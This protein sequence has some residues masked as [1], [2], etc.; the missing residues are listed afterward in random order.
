M[1]VRLIP[2]SHNPARKIIYYGE[3]VDGEVKVSEKL[4]IYEKLGDLCC[5]V[6]AHS[7][8]LNFYGQQVSLMMPY[9]HI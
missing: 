1:T 8:A 2:L 5:Q 7:A 9:S 4:K 6:K 3:K